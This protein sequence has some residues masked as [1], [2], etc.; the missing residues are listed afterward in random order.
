MMGDG[1]DSTG[2][3]TAAPEFVFYVFGLVLGSAPPNTRLF[4][5]EFQECHGA[6][7]SLL[8]NYF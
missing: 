1:A 5:G 6:M 3:A 8:G 7:L 4:R 2:L